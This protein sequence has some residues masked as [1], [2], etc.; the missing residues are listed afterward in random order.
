MQSRMPPITPEM[1]LRAYAGGIFPMAENRDDRQIFWVDPEWRGVFLPGRF[2]TSRSLSR[3]IRRH[4]WRVTTDQAFDE[5]V[6]NCADRPETWINEEIRQLYTALYRMGHAHSVEVWEENSL[7]GGVY[8]VSLGGAFFGESMFSRRD[9]SSKLALAWL[10]HRLFAGG[11]SLFDTQFLTPHLAS[12]GA[13]EIPRSHYLRLLSTAL[14]E[15]ACFDPP[16]YSPSPDSVA[17]VSGMA[18]AGNMQ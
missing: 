10:A 3:L 15:D 13:I 12:L 2:H 8:G 1:L 6:L 11:F 14:S 5:V 18:C 4:P 7:I 9:N 17:S 16:G